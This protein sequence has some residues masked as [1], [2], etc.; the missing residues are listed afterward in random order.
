MKDKLKQLI[1][2]YPNDYIVIASR[3][4]SD[5]NISDPYT[6]K[7]V[8]NILYDSWLNQL[9]IDWKVGIYQLNNRSLKSFIV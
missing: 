5:L 3:W 4:G 2:D 7:S 9:S 1:R 8:A 6:Y